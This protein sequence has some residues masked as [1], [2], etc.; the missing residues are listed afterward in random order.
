MD[1]PAETI[2]DRLSFDVA[3]ETYHLDPGETLTF[4]R[5]GNAVVDADNP[6]MHRVVG[7]LYFDRWGWWLRNSA[8]HMPMSMVGDDDR[9]KTLPAGA[10]EPL[11]TP[12]GSVRFY[13]G[14]TGYELT[15]ELSGPSAAPDS[16]AGL[17]DTIDATTADFGKVRLSDNQRTMMVV[18]AEQRLRRPGVPLP[19]PTNAEIAARCGWTLKQ[20]DRKLDYLCRRLADS[21]VPGLRGNPGTE[22]AN[23]RELLVMHVLHNGLITTDDLALLGGLCPSPTERASC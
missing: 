6:Y 1:A 17:P 2:A 22:A 3:E 19:L 21:G 9:H 4:G 20:F 13:A 23:R 11:T 10:A 16:P 5:A 14:A 15:W 12:R 18:M 7:L 8:K